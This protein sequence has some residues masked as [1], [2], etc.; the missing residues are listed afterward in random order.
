MTLISQDLYEYLDKKFSE[1]HEK[2]NGIDK[3][4]ATLEN[5]RSWA[6]RTASFVSAIV[7]S[8]V[9][10]LWENFAGGKK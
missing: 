3:K 7:G 10:L 9:V 4:V 5:D 6:F 8:V 2:I 1:L